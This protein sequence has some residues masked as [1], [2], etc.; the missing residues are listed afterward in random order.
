MYVYVYKY[1]YIYI[2]IYTCI[3]IPPRGAIALGSLPRKESC[4]PSG[5]PAFE[6]ISLERQ[7]IS[8]HIS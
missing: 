5:G 7:S 4:S 3:H 2:Y 8:I 6:A 1:I